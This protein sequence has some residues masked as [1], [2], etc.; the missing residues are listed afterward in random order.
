MAAALVV[1]HLLA[2]NA[3]VT[4]VVPAARIMAGR[5]PPKTPLPAIAISQVGNRNGFAEVSKQSAYRRTRVQVTVVTDAYEQV[6]E[7]L[8][9]VR[10]A[11]RRRRGE[12]AGVAVES[13]LQDI[14]GPDSGEDSA[15]IFGRSQDFI[16]C[17][18]G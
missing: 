7:L 17:H 1:R 16:V 5:L 8:G 2:A 11:V 6:G 14:E 15:E 10:A 13:I 12:I 18:T 3:E 9:L 4:A